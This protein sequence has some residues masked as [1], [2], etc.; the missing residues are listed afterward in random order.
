[1]AFSVYFNLSVFLIRYY[2]R[3]KNYG[4]RDL[5]SFEY[6]YGDVIGDVAYIS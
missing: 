5:F 2:S 3:F 1:M 4:K 6:L